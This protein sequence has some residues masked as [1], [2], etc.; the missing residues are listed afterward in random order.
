MFTL[1]KKEI[2]GFFS[3]LTGY[4]VVLVFLLA[5][6]LIMWIMPG[7]WN[8]LDSGY[9]GLDTLFVI[10]PWLFLFLVPAV[11]MK[12][13]AEEKRQGTLE[14]LFSRPLGEGSIIYGKFFSAVALVFLSLLPCIV[15]VVSVW[16][17]G[18]TPGNFDKGGTAGSFIG[19]F[20]LA[21][22]Y[23]SIGLFS[24]SLTENQVVAFIL[25]VIISMFVWIGFDAIAMLP[26]LASIDESIVRL[27]INEHY[28]SVS[29]G[30][31][32]L[33]D[34]AY[35][36]FLTAL[37]NEATRFVLSKRNI[38]KP[39]SVL[40]VFALISI[41]MS[42][43]HFRIDM[44]EDRR[45]TLSDPTRKILREL[46][47]DVHVNVYLDGD[48]PI[49]LKKLRRS[50][51][52]YLDEFRVLSRRKISYEF[53]N[54]SEGSNIEEREKLQNELI[55]KGM[56]PVNVMASDGEG[57]KS[58]KWVFPSMTIGCGKI[59]IPVNF[60]QNNP[61][62]SAETN[63]L[64]STEGLEY[65]IIQAI[66]I[67]TSDTVHKVAF[68]E[69]HGELDEVYVGDITLE[70]AK[71]FSIDRGKIGGTPGILDGYSAIIV[72]KPEEAF[73]E[74]DKYVIDQYIMNGGRV[75]WLAEEVTLNA[76]SLAYGGTVGLYKPL[77][78]DDQLF[79]Y[80]VRINPVIIEDTECMVIPIKI[81]GP[82]GQPQYVP[83]PWI[84]YPLLKPSDSSPV[85]RNLNRVR[86][87]F[88]NYIDTVGRDPGIKKKILLTTSGRSRALTPPVYISL[89]ETKDPPSEEM[90][91][92]GELPVAVLLEGKFKSAFANRMTESIIGAEGKKVITEGKLSKMI[93]VADGDIIR[94]DVSW[95]R[96]VPEPLPL[97]QD[98]YTQQTYGNKDFIVN[99]LN[100]LVFDNGL[101]EM[102]SREIKPR[103]LNGKKIDEQRVLWQV[104]NTILP[105]ILLVLSGLAYTHIRRRRYTSL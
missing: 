5:N 33:R 99:C 4:I 84:Y 41:A 3:S 1:F 40:A 38:K 16:I 97:G 20:L 92:L 25:A 78:I 15:F 58:Q 64:H 19:L 29:R 45:F 81:S 46:K 11:T 70:L 32:D 71:Y 18:E 88:A 9:A 13:F 50:T 47:S 90:F 31:I 62:L 104:V 98:R 14:L 17:L 96:G 21:S 66:A 26:G 85:T 51:E 77:T 60:L 44:T 52:Q 68:I 22:V 35:F 61:T 2:A 82:G 56:F 89:E 53:I 28:K 105:A 55:N 23:A 95:T 101:M 7:Q 102:R 63:L 10:S 73:D 49:G 48:M 36:V 69:G 72:A 67:A 8:L 65:E 43:F 37:F 93:V 6:S 76:D 57:G 80:G 27:G 94:N 86:S 34:I 79:R 91:T 74:K 24:S 103:L 100:Y 75:L 59:E 12:M 83:A 30:V 39:A 87:E 54:P 42:L